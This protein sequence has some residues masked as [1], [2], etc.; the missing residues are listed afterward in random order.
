MEIET[1]NIKQKVKIFTN[2]TYFSHEDDINDWL[3]KNNV[4]IIKTSDLYNTTVD[5][6]G[7]TKNIKYITYIYYKQL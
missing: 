1:K 7:Y 6:H 4:E 5:S 3:N 2:E